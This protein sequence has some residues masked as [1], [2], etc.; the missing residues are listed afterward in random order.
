VKAVGIA[1]GVILAGVI[2]AGVILAGV[3][4]YIMVEKWLLRKE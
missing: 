1:S 2:L 4:V 3:L